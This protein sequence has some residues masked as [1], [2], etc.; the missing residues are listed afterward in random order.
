MISGG[1]KG[2]DL[3]SHWGGKGGKG[4]QQD[5]EGQGEKILGRKRGEDLGGKGERILT[6]GKD[7][8]E[9]KGEDLRPGK[10]WTSS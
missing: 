5:R 3:K 2:E 8:G 9:E 10:G 1:E 6:G 7:L 4:S